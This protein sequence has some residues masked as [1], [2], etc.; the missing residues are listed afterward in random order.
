MQD[1]KALA[2]SMTSSK[3]I[4]KTIRAASAEAVL[5][6]VAAELQDAGFYLVDVR[7]A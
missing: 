1:F 4:T 3:R 5:P 7:P 2:Q 6:L